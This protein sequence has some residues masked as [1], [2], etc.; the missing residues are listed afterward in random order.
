MRHIETRDAPVFK[1]RPYVGVRNCRR[2][3]FSQRENKNAWPTAED[4][5]ARQRDRKWDVLAKL[6][7]ISLDNW[8]VSQYK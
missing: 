7:E 4:K 8:I 1:L 3:G 5:S 2:Q 6:I